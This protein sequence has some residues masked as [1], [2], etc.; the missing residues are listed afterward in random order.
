[1][2]AS[3]ADGGATPSALDKL[4]RGGEL[5]CQ[6]TMPYFCSNLHV[7]CAGQTSLKT[8][9]FTL[10]VIHAQ[11]KIVS[12]PDPDNVLMLYDNGHVQVDRDG[13]YAIL[14]PP[15]G[16][17]YIRLQSDGSYSLRHYTLHGAVMSI[18]RCS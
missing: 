10:K 9:A 18:G 11:S 4:T 7:A 16:S 6:P 1:V 2:G 5:A 15:Q 13:A 12:A 8:F 17:G 14:L 3:A